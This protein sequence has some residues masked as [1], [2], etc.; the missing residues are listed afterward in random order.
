MTDHEFQLK[1]T[2]SLAEIKTM[3]VSAVGSDGNGGKLQD[4]DERVTE[5]EHNSWK[6]TGMASVVGSVFGAIGAYLFGHK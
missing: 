2:E 1:V 3:L 6:R 4:V 5:L